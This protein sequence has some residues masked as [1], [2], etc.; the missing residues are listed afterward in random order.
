MNLLNPGVDQVIIYNGDEQYTLDGNDI[1]PESTLVRRVQT[2]TASRGG[3]LPFL[4]EHTLELKISDTALYDAIQGQRF[5]LVIEK[6]NGYYVWGVNERLIKEED[7]LFDPES[8]EYPLI[9]KAKNISETPAIGQQGNLLGEFI[10]FDADGVADG[11]SV[12]GGTTSSFVNGKQTVEVNVEKELDFAYPGHLYRYSI[13]FVALHPNADNVIRYT[14]S[15]AGG[16]LSTSDIAVASV[17]VVTGSVTAP[18]GATKV[19]IQARANSI[20]GAG[21]LTIRNPNLYLD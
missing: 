19:S 20:V 2:R 9:I 8:Q 14:F 18:A 15:D 11:W 16:V 10:D 3:Y 12:T 4:V 13:D 1:S 17:G 5:N 21:S 7:I 6:F